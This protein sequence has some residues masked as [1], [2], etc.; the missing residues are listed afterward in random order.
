MADDNQPFS[1]ELPDGSLV[2]SDDVAGLLAE[3]DG[4][5]YYTD[6]TGRIRRTP[7]MRPIIRKGLQA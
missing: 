1:A 6:H 7:G 4:H 3:L 5:R 2:I